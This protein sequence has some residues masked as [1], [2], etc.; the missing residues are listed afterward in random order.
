MLE[1]SWLGFLQ[2]SLEL[3]MPS[4]A[5]RSCESVPI[6]PAKFMWIRLF[7]N[8]V[9]EICL[10]QLHQLKKHKLISNNLRN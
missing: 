5:P 2:G 3:S 9:K 8:T 1:P 7:A 10:Y 4:N 6:V